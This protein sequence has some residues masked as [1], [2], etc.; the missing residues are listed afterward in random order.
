MTG[1]TSTGGGGRCGRAGSTI[2]PDKVM[3]T[4]DAAIKVLMLLDMGCSL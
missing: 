1:T 2:Q 3:A 4:S